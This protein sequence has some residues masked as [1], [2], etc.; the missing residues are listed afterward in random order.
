VLL[1]LRFGLDALV[2]AADAVDR[3]TASFGEFSFLPLNLSAMTVIEPSSSVRVT[4]RPLCSQV[5]RR[6][7][8]SMVLPFEFID[9]CR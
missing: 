9:G 5:I 4:R 6:P 2:I 8:R 1:L 7:S 3:I